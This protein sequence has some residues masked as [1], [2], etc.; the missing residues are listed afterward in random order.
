MEEIAESADLATALDAQ[1]AAVTAELEKYREGDGWATY[2]DLTED[3]LRGL[4]DSINALAAE[5]SQVPQVV[6]G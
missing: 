3:Q 6:A 1:F 5:V 4:S 2:T